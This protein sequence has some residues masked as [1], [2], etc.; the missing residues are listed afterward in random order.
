MV[1]ASFRDNILQEMA[2][3][4]WGGIDKRLWKRWKGIAV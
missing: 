3:G 1:V 2:D 4:K